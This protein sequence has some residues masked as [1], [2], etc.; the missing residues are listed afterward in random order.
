MTTLFA[1]RKLQRIPFWQIHDLADTEK[2]LTYRP[3]LDYLRHV[4]LSRC[5]FCRET[6]E[7]CTCH[8]PFRDLSI[9]ETK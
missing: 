7:W 2:P 6:E 4:D 8:I 1:A 5:G 9:K 3:E